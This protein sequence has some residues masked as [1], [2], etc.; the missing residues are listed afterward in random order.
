VLC[1]IEKGDDEETS[2]HKRYVIYE[3]E[4]NWNEDEP[5]FYD[6]KN[7][8]ETTRLKLVGQKNSAP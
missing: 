8:G 5:T 1:R 3:Y 2:R 4:S 6:P 7:P